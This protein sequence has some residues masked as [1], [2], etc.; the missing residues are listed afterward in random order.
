MA[1]KKK[2]QKKSAKKPPQRLVRVSQATLDKFDKAL[3]LIGPITKFNDYTVLSEGDV[4]ADAVRG[5]NL[6]YAYYRKE[7]LAQQ[8]NIEPLS[9]PDFL[10][11]LSGIILDEGLE[12]FASDP[13]GIVRATDEI[14]L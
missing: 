11:Y 10:Y 1:R 12:F 8:P 14:A 2:K 4:V 3:T 5:F 9:K 7:S 6:I 13:S